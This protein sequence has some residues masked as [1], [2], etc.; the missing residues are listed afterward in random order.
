MRTSWKTLVLSVLGLLATQPIVRSQGQEPGYIESF[1]LAKDRVAALSQLIPGTEDYYYYHCLHALNLGQF[2][3]ID[4]FTRPWLERFGQTQRLHEIQTRA[5]LLSLEKDPKK[6][7][8]YLKG[9]TG[10]QFNHQREIVGVAPNLPTSFDQKLVSRATLLGM[11]LV[12]W[13]NLD[14]FE[15]SALDWLAKE[16]LDFEKRRN[17]LQRVVRPDTPNI[18]Q[19]MVDDDQAPHPQAF[20]A[21]PVSV[22]LTLSQLE[23]LVAKK[24]LWL[25]HPAILQSWLP[26]LQPGA[27]SDWRR[28]PDQVAAFLDRLKAFSD[29]LAPVH[30]GLKAHIQYQRLV[31]DRRQGVLSKARLLEYLALPR[32]QHY[33]A[34]ALIEAEAS[35]RYPANLGMDY[36]SQTLLPPVG[37]D[38]EVVRAYLKHFLVDAESTREYEPFVNANYLRHLFAEVKVENG[39]G[40]SE[41]WASLLPPESFKALRERIDIDFAPTNRAEFEVDEPVVLDLF[42]KNVP[43]LMVKVFE[44]NTGNFYKA[45]LSEIDTDINLDGLVANEEKTHAY[46]DAPLRRIARR[47]A[48]KLDKPGVYVVDFIGSGKSSRA[49]IRKGRLHGLVSTTPGGQAV[50]VLDGKNQKV[51]DATVWLSGKEYKP[52]EKGLV[53]LPFS[54]EPG[55]RHIVLSRGGQASLDEFNH[56]GEDYQFTAGLHVDR[57]ALL[58]QRMATLLVRPGLRL[59]GVPVSLKLLEEVR[60]RITSTDTQGINTTSEVPSFKLLEDRETTHEFRVPEGTARLVFT[61]EAKVKN[62]SRGRTDTVLAQNAVDLNGI[63]KTDKIEDIHL[64]HSAEGIVL[65]VLGRTGE[66]RPDRAVNITVKHRDFRELVHAS[67]KSDAKGRVHLGKLEGVVRVNAT[68]SEGIVHSWPIEGDKASSRRMIHAVAGE[69]VVLPYTGTQIQAERAEFSLFEM[70]GNL[71]KA[72]RFGAI[73]VVNGLVRVEGLE[74]GDYELWVKPASEPVRIRIVKGEVIASHV[75]GET[76]NLRVLPLKPLSVGEMRVEGNALVIRVENASAFSRIHLFGTRYQPGL[77]AFAQMDKVRAPELDGVYPG[78][79]PSVY[80]TGRN[81]GDEYRYVLDRRAQKKY[82][83]VMADRPTMLLNPWAVRETNTGEQLAM[84]GEA[85]GAKGEVAPPRSA[86]AASEMAAKSQGMAVDVSAFADFDFLANASTVFANLVPDKEGILKIDLKDLGGHELIHAVVCDPLQTATRSLTL[87]LG[88]AKLLD[89]R[90]RKGLDPQGKFLREKKVSILSKATAFTVE[91]IRSSKFEIYD[92]LG[93]VHRLFHTLNKDAALVEFS[94]LIHWPSLKVEEKRTLLSK[95]GCHELHFFIHQKDTPF[96]EEVVR[97]FLANKKDKTFVDRWLLNEDLSGFLNPWEYARLNTMERVLLAKRLKDEP[98]K[99]ARHIEERLRLTPPNIQNQIMWFDTAVSSSGLGQA[100]GALGDFREKLEQQAIQEK[101]AGATHF[102]LGKQELTL[103]QPLPASEPAAPPPPGGPMGGGGAAMGRLADPQSNGRMRAGLQRGVQLEADAKKLAVNERFVLDG[104]KKDMAKAKGGDKEVEQKD[105]EGLRAIDRTAK[106]DA[107]FAFNRNEDKLGLLYRPIEGTKEYAENNYRN[108]PI[109]AQTAGLVGASA[110]WLDY[111]RHEGKEP[112]LSKNIAEASRNFTESV[113]ALAVT[114]LPFESAK[115][116]IKYEA[117]KLIAVPGSQA[118]A[119]HEEVRPA[120]A[121]VNQ[122]AILVSQNFYRLGE[123]FRDENG[124]KLDKFITAEFLSQTGYG[125]QIVVT[126]PT[127]SRR[128]LTLL[129]QIPV[130][131]IGLSPSQA[132]RS[133]PLDL[134]PYRTQTIDYSFYFPVAGKYPQLPVQ[135]SEKGKSVASGLAMVFLVLNKPS[136]ADTASWDYISQFGTEKEVLDFLV[137][138]N[139]QALNLDKIAFRMNDRAFFGQVTELLATRHVYHNTLWSYGLLHNDQA[140]AGEFLKHNDTIVND[141]AG[142]I[143][144][145]LLIVNPVQRHQYEHLEYKPLVNA[146]AHALGAKRIIVND[147]LAEQYRSFLKLLSYQRLLG[148]NENLSLVV[149]LLLQDRIE[150]ASEAFA[151]IDPAKVPGKIAYDYAKAWLL[152]ATEQPDKAREIAK[153]HEKHPVDRWRESFVRI[154]DQIDEA[155]GKD[156]AGKPLDPENRADTQDK[157]AAAEPSFDLVIEGSKVNLSWQ[158]VKEVTVN[159]YLMDV[160]LLFSRNPFVQQAGGEFAFIKPNLTKV[161]KLDTVKGKVDL[162]LP[163]ELAKRNLLVEVT[164][165]GKTRTAAYYSSAMDVKLF[166]NQG[167][168]KVTS[169]DGTKPLAK[170][171]VKVYA[172]FADGTVKFHKDG[173]SDLRGRFDY[174]TVSTPEKQPITR[175]SVLILS[176]DQG[177]SIRETNP[178][179]R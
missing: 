92:N 23:D 105:S 101:R 172:R 46:E 1:S 106:P 161:V 42:V 119:F 113:F 74:A 148:D 169:R 5:A 15:D 44:V 137:R 143:Q 164:A 173:Y 70:V 77:S 163:L 82:P 22:K 129:I 133:I 132:T 168:L 49:L 36:S 43:S 7:F 59:S 29:R 155:Q 136:K 98:A 109:Q 58:S 32:Q 12:R 19:H 123:R 177:A 145:P 165:A 87:P 112:F 56:Q 73:K 158:S 96:F 95:H 130:G 52:D 154:L 114:D 142:P 3:K 179:Q 116:D 118:I 54:T 65:E 37:S 150:E 102:G 117:G 86:A 170:V 83:G 9:R 60:L 110:F 17:L 178:P 47:F 28:H 25:N 122:T 61:L 62:L 131:G 18:I 99:T 21:Y 67:L 84:Q 108:L 126:N 104:A 55:R 89:Q 41:R 35:V 57:E 68:G 141:C 175:F 10:V 6:T 97:P 174:A 4:G 24:P 146:R 31:H 38:E 63:L 76:R 45:N 72:D 134:E 2:E 140:T 107:F 151:K 103:N 124:E 162:G 27:D 81:I 53:L 135:V 11:S 153:L 90:L 147:R 159:Y 176:E 111:V 85:F 39:L 34:K 66:P 26:K 128:K 80:V 75:L 48:F 167:Q 139:L 94:F 152:L 144:S 40:D 14:N 127:S 50:T 16:T 78:R 138:E 160:E 156:A 120:E 20:G 166:E 13:R 79:S 91:D 100:E 125:C 69:V 64:I 30:N 115:H 157:L 121:A 171:Y 93:K 8:E 149:Y 51:N 88:D 71:P 33:M